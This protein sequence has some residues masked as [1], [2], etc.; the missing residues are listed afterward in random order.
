M[1]QRTV[2]IIFMI[3]FCLFVFQFQGWNVNLHVKLYALFTCISILKYFLL[4][5]PCE[6]YALQTSDL[7]TEIQAHFHCLI[8]M[9]DS[10]RG[11]SFALK[12][13][14][15]YFNNR[16]QFSRITC[17]K[18]VFTVAKTGVCKSSYNH[19]NVFKTVF[20]IVHSGMIATCPID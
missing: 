2:I 8:I 16:E 6:L 10:I 3:V 15:F 20:L 7:L 17:I 12:R 19:I 13:K 9:S 4:T 5:P 11:K 1:C 14:L 18:C